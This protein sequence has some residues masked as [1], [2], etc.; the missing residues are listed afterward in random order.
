MA[1]ITRNV[2]A[3]KSRPAQPAELDKAMTFGPVKSETI[4]PVGTR[5]GYLRQ[6]QYQGARRKKVAL[7]GMYK[8]HAGR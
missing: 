6:L 2:F 8:P 1:K 5:V 3:P 4:G 7:Q